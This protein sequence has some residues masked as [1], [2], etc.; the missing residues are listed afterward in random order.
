[1]AAISSQSFEGVRGGGILVI[2]ITFSFVPFVVF[3]QSSFPVLLKFLCLDSVYQVGRF[4]HMSCDPSSP[5]C[6]S[7]FK[8]EILNRVLK[9]SKYLEK[10]YPLVQ[11]A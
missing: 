6:P 8:S 5:V 3:S 11:F 9:N 4:S 2:T 10:V 7:V 1:M